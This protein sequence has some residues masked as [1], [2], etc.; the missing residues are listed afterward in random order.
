M[1]NPIIVSYQKFL[2]QWFDSA[3]KKS[4]RLNHHH[5]SS[6]EFVRTD[7]YL[8][9]G[10]SLSTYNISSRNLLMRDHQLLTK[11]N[12]FLIVFLCNDLYSVHFNVLFSA[13]VISKDF[14]SN[15]LRAKLLL[16]GISRIRVSSYRCDTARR[17]QCRLMITSSW[18]YWMLVECVLLWL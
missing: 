11:I 17:V 13:F 14:V 9:S 15:F 7:S 3:M 5:P 6:D 2:L 8:C 12:V 18:L 10:A 1:F 4:C 16:S